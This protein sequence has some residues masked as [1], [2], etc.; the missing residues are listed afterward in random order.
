MARFDP[1]AEI[2]AVDTN[3]QLQPFGHFVDEAI[4][5]GKQVSGVDQD[6]GDRRNDARCQAQHHRRLGAKARAEDERV[7]KLERSPADALLGGYA[8]KPPFA[9]AASTAAETF[10][11]VAISYFRQQKHPRP[12]QRPDGLP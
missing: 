10:S 8:G 2:S 6:D 11:A 3:V 9:A 1:A 7:A 4:R 12:A 5:L